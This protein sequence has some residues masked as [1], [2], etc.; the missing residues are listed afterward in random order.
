MVSCPALSSDT[1]FVRGMLGYVDCQA[2]QIG[3]GG[4]QALASPGSM[5]SLLVTGFL[6]LFVGL[7]GYRML[8]GHTPSLREGVLAL[9]KVGAVLALTMSWP[10]YR[11]LIYEVALHGPVELATEISQAGV[12]PG[13]GGDVIDHL[14]YA[15]K[16]LVALAASVADGAR[17][18]APSGRT[19]GTVEGGLTAFTPQP[20][21]GFDTF[22]IGGAR[23]IF[24]IAA[25]GALAAVH[26]V[27]GLLLA[28]GPFF[29]AFLLFE[30]T[31][32]LF[33]GWVRA[34]AG[35]ALGALG[36]VATVGVEL[37]LIEPW[38][39]DLLAR[40]AAGE[41]V[42]GAPA[43][44]LVVTLI[45][46]LVLIA[47]LMAAGKV[48]MGFRLPAA[49]A[50]APA[51]LQAI[52]RERQAPLATMLPPVPV[53]RVDIRSRAATVVE[54]IAAIQRREAAWIDAPYGDM[55]RRAGERVVSRSAPAAL[56]P[57]PLGQSFRRRAQA[58]VSTSAMQRD[59]GA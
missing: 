38:L 28:L 26:L 20:F 34:L 33:E 48:A 22:A 50:A 1:G 29:I 56:P 40:R 2:Q 59:R 35:A 17:I 52:I 16:E 30:S 44:V 9:V 12:L 5:L 31:R 21:A 46:A 43:E 39:A 53:E 47:V 51:R 58:R 13:A 3:A 49:W 10:T 41:P 15:D 18:A 24:L 54:A 55:L 37:A 14:D 57:T 36:T 6:T 11:M 45:F 7:F 4:Y 19:A 23:M 27:S 32:G 8:F 25:I 42:P